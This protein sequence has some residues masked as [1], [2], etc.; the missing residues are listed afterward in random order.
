VG[1]FPLSIPPGTVPLSAVVASLPAAG[2]STAILVV[3]NV[4]DL[5]TDRRADKRTL[6]VML[7]YRFS[8]VEF[9]LAVGMAY[10]V[11][12]VFFATGFG[13]FVLLPLLTAPL[14][15]RLGRTVFAR[16]DGA[17][18]NPAL[19]ATGKLLAA[20]SVLFAVGLALPRFV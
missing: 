5:E 12:V 13:P 3:N 20:H 1:P 7:G 10:V 11:P 17:A 18:L 9:A 8:R 14:A 15:I 16:T 6:A 4:R 19:E 2:L